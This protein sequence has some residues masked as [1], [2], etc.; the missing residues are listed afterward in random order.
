MDGVFEMEIL[1]HYI[2]IY[3]FCVC[4]CIVRM[5]Y[6]HVLIKI[7]LIH[8]LQESMIYKRSK[9]VQDIQSPTFPCAISV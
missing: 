2:Y 7:Q 8:L 1:A 5:W 6:D 4:V 3:N 9:K